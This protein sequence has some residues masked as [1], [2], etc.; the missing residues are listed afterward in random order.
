[1]GLLINNIASKLETIKDRIEACW[2]WFKT[3]RGISYAIG[4]MLL[5]SGYVGINT[6]SAAFLMMITMTLPMF[7]ILWWS[8]KWTLSK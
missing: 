4:F 7:G 3:P 1:M 5:L 8:K 6:G 2:S